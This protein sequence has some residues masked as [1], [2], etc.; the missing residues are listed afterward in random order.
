MSTPVG[1]PNL[2]MW[3]WVQFISVENIDG[4]FNVRSTGGTNGTQNGAACEVM[5][6]LTQMKTLTLKN[7]VEDVQVPT[8]NVDFMVNG[9]VYFTFNYVRPDQAIHNF[10][11]TTLVGNFGSPPLIL[12]KGDTFNWR[13]IDGN[14]PNNSDRTHWISAV[15]ADVI[16]YPLP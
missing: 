7:T 16:G 4:R 9:S 15:W 12:N 1:N 8:I 14:R 3:E 2:Y 11:L 13:I 10:D 6:D 5:N